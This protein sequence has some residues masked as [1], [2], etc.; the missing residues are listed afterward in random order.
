MTPSPKRD[1]ETLQPGAAAIFIDLD[2][3]DL[4]TVEY[5]LL[6]NVCSQQGIELHAYAQKDRPAANTATHTIKSNEREAVQVQ[7]IWDIATYCSKHDSAAHVLIVTDDHLGK[8]LASLDLASN[9]VTWASI[10]RELPQPWRKALSTTSIKDF[11]QPDE[12]RRA[13]SRSRSRSRG[14]SLSRDDD[15]RDDSRST[16]ASSC[17]TRASGSAGHTEGRPTS[18]EPISEGEPQ[19]CLICSDS[20]AGAPGQGQGQGRRRWL[21]CGNGCVH[22]TAVADTPTTSVRI[23][24]RCCQAADMFAASAA[25]SRAFVPSR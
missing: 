22:P 4:E 24:E 9:K 14:C 12:R 15:L 2:N 5:P 10:E 8:T 7:M 20:P 23:F 6:S 18:P 19:Q 17:R 25:A 13:R 1:L 11:F 16:S 21:F 3:V